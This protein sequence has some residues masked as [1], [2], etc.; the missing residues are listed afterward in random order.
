MTQVSQTSTEELG[1][2]RQAM[3]WLHTWGGLVAS[4]VLFAIFLTGTICVF[5]D[6][7]TRW[8]NP[9]RVQVGEFD[10]QASTQ[11]QRLESVSKGEA[12][13]REIAPQSHLWRIR[14]PSE[15]DP[16]I[17]LSWEDEY[18]EFQQVRL[19][20]VTGELLTP[21]QERETEGGHHFVHMHFEFHAGMAGIWMVGFFTMIMLV[22]LVSGIIIHKRIFK[23]F[24]TFR[25]GK[26]Q[27]SWLDAHNASSVL[28]LPF[29]L[30]I[31]YTGLIIFVSIYMPAGVMANYD[32]PRTFFA[33]VFNQPEHRPET[34]IE[35]DVY[36]LTELFVKAEAHLKKPAGFISVEHPGDSSAVAKIFG[37]FEAEKNA[38][39]LLFL[40]QG[41]VI[42]DAVTGEL[43]HIEVP[44][45]FDKSN[46]FAAQ[47]IMRTLHFANFGGYTVRWIYFIL[48]MAGTVMMATG[49]ILFMVK[50][51]QR[52]LN[53]FGA[54]TPKVYRIIEVLNISAISGL[55]V[56]CV[57]YFWVNRLLPL[58]FTG[59]A[60]W[61]I[62]L[63]SFV[64]LG[65]LLHAALRPASRAWIEQLVAFVALCLLLPVMNWLT[66]GQHLIVY[67]MQGDW[68]NVA[69]E[70]TVLLF[71]V[72]GVFTV[73]ILK[74][75]QQK[76]VIE[77]SRIYKPKSEAA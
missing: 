15:A 62:K 32:S 76:A 33:E 58:E 61:E 20:P 13:L 49:A 6:A 54:Q 3:A 5:D 59:R 46:A 64:W 51:R 23:D 37:V 70:L 31:A 29:Q 24:F 60:G 7:I 42:L 47:R 22:V 55:M 28:S 41:Q 26:G 57:A 16:A 43:L 17:G 69:F 67:L 11:Q 65:S 56:A 71:G 4:W 2:F 53:E 21:Q 77:A 25:S 34:G 44:D 8:M 39:R 18:D 19:H 50:R 1:G 12:Y 9:E 48:G 68:V 45:M 30:M 36:P 35:A 40:S 38:G 10:P 14:L 75:K 63:F 72:L 27:R 74:R 73:K 66:T 52:S